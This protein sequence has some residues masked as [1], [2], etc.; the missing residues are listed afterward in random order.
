MHG[1]VTLDA[2][3]AVDPPG[4]PLERPAHGRRVRGD[5]GSASGF[6]R[7]IALTGNRALTGFTAPKLLWLRTHEPD[8]LRAHRARDAAEGLRAAA[9][10]RRARDRR[11]RRVRHAAARRRGPALERRGARRAGARPRRGCRACSSRRR[12]PGAR[13]TGIAGGGRRGRPGGRRARRRRRPARAA[14]GRARHVRRRVRR[15]ARVRGRPAGARARVLPRGAG[16]V[17]RDGRDALGRRLAARGCA[18]SSA[19]EFAELVERGR[20]VGARASRG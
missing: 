16:R 20:R 10:D 11:R 2:A 7:L 8:D 6:E 9:A 1:L 19:G 17:A 12:C 15:A 3:D 4:D 18:T 14:V 13:A 5:R